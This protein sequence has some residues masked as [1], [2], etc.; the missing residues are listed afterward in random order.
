MHA[1]TKAQILPRTMNSVTKEKKIML[2]DKLH[3]K[4]MAIDDAPP[5][6]RTQR[7][8]KMLHNAQRSSRTL[9]FQ[10]PLQVQ[11]I[12]LTKHC[13]SSP[14][15]PTLPTFFPLLNIKVELDLATRLTQLLPLETRLYQL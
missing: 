13:A 5:T 3:K 15:F 4:M 1:L 7:L 6:I 9:P 11:Q 10:M 8:K 12:H 14:L 2:H